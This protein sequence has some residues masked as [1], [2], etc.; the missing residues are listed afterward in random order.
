MKKKNLTVIKKS[1]NSQCSNTR[2]MCFT[3]KDHRQYVFIDA[4]KYRNG[5]H[6]LHSINNNC[7]NN[8]TYS[9]LGHGFIRAWWVQSTCSGNFLKLIKWYSDNNDNVKKIMDLNALDNN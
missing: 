1:I 4:K 7:N 3:Y 2:S 8:S 9:K 5:R 6:I